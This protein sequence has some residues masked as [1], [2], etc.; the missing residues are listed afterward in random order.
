MIL[1]KSNKYSKLM[2]ARAILPIIAGLLILYGAWE[3]LPHVRVSR[4][5]VLRGWWKSEHIK[6]ACSNKNFGL[7]CRLGW[8][9]PLAQAPLAGSLLLVCLLSLTNS[10][11]LILKCGDVILLVVAS[12]N[13]RGFPADYPCMSADE[14]VPRKMS[15]SGYDI[16]PLT[17]EQL[18]QQA[19]K[20]DANTRWHSYAVSFIQMISTGVKSISCPLI[21]V[22]L[23]FKS[24]SGGAWCGPFWAAG[25]SLWSPAQS[26][27][28][29]EKQS[30]VSHKS[31]GMIT[32]VC[33]NMYATTQPIACLHIE[34]ESCRCFQ[35]FAED[36]FLGCRIPPWHQ[37]RG[38]VG[39]CNWGSPPIFIRD[40]VWLWDRMA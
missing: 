1:R 22:A 27:P 26:E 31:I 33:R 29:L 14:S 17:K 8:G 6:S 3:V 4:L 40:K 39:V 13:M 2:T 30:M 36:H 23:W 20:V 12:S 16:T 10:L 34:I 37:E 15:K 18:A 19:A 24:F 32:D 11:F 21:Q 28:S 5:A 9:L 35:T 38:T 7:L 25:I